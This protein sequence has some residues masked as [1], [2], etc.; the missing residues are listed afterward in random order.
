MRASF[1]NLFAFLCANFLY[2]APLRVRL[3]KMLIK[4]YTIHV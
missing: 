3:C 4:H 1:S 2:F